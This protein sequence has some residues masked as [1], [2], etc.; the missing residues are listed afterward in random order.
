MSMLALLICV[1]YMLP[2]TGCTRAGKSDIMLDLE[3][4]RCCREHTK[5]ALQIERHCS[6]H[7]LFYDMHIFITGLIAEHCSSRGQ[8]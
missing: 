7:Y 2:Y 4:E 6:V 5:R 8:A 3:G 1:A